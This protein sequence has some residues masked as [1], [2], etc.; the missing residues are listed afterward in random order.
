MATSKSPFSPHGASRAGDE[1]Q[2]LWGIEIL[3]DWLEHP[4]R[5][6]WVRFEYSEAGALDDVVAK[7]SSGGLICRQMKHTVDPS[8]EEYAGS[9]DWLCKQPA[10]TQG[11]RPSMLQHW[12]AALDR[13]LDEGPIEEA[14]LYTNRK[15]EP[16]LKAALVGRR[17]DLDRLADAAVRQAIED[18]L[19]GPERA[20]AF[21]DRFNFNLDLPGYEAFEEILKTRFK[22]SLGGDERGWAGLRD[23]ARTWA[24]RRDRASDQGRISLDDIRR[25]ALWHDPRA[26]SQEFAVPAD[27]ALPDPAMWDAL[28][29]EL[30]TPGSGTIVLAAGPGFGK[31]TFLSHLAARL[32]AQGVPVIR[33]HYYMAARERAE[34]RFRHTV[35]L[36]SLMAQMLSQHADLLG[37]Y[38]TRNP[39]VDDF[40]HWLA[41]AGVAADARGTSLTVVIDGLDHVWRQQG[42]VS[43]LAHLFNR[44]LPPPDGV[45]VVIGTQPL[46]DVHLPPRLLDH[47]PRDT[48]RTLPPL[49]EPAVR[50][51]LNGNRHRL[52]GIPP[53]PAGDHWLAEAATAFH[54][55][56][57]GHPLH[58]RYSMEA[59]IAHDLP[60][61]SADIISL[62][63]CPAGDI[64][65]YYDALCRGL[66]ETARRQLHLFAV[67]GFPWPQ[68]AL[69]QVLDPAR[70]HRAATRAALRSIRHLFQDTEQGLVPF[71]ASLLDHLKRSRNYADDREELLERVAAWLE[72]P[73][74]EPWRWAY[75][76][77]ILAERGDTAALIAGPT[78]A[79]LADAVARRRPARHVDRILTQ[80]GRCALKAGDL[81]RVVEIQVL[82]GYAVSAR[83]LHLHDL[84]PLT[85]CALC[86]TRRG[87][88]IKEMRADRLERPTL[89]VAALAE[90]TITE[91]DGQ[92]LARLG[93]TTIVDRLNSL[94][95]HPHSSL[96][97]GQRIMRALPCLLGLRM[98]TPTDLEIAGIGELAESGHPGLLVFLAARSKLGWWSD[99]PDLLARLTDEADRYEMAIG[100]LRQAT[101]AGIDWVRWSD[102]ACW[103]DG[104]LARAIDLA[105]GQ[106]SAQSLSPLTPWPAP[107]GDRFAYR[108]NGRRR[109]VLDL[110]RV[111]FACLI[112]AWGGGAAPVPTAWGGQARTAM[113]I[114]AE[115][116][117]RQLATGGTLDL[118]D[119]V[120]TLQR[121]ERDPKEGITD[122]RQREWDVRRASAEILLDLV[123]VRR[124]A[125]GI[126]Q[127]TAAEVDRMEAATGMLQSVRDALLDSRLAWLAPDALERFITHERNRLANVVE[128]LYQ[129]YED[130]ARCAWL[131][132]L[133]RPDHPDLERLTTLAARCALGYGHRK[134]LLLSE[135]MGAIEALVATQPAAVRRWIKRLVPFIDAVS[136]FTDGKENA[137]HKVGV[138]EVLLTLAPGVVPAY[139]RH[140]A[141]HDRHRADQVTALYIAGVDPET[142]EA[143]ALIAQA[144]GEATWKALHPD[145]D[146]SVG[147]D[148]P[149]HTEDRLR[150]LRPAEAPPQ[151][152]TF[153]P[154]RFVAF[155]SAVN[156]LPWNDDEDLFLAWYRHWRRQDRPAALSALATVSDQEFYPSRLHAT[157]LEAFHDVR[158]TAGARAAFPWL[159]RAHRAAMGWTFYWHREEMARAVWAEL[160]RHYPADWHT[161]IQATLA[162]DERA[163]AMP[164]MFGPARLVRFLVDMNQEAL[165]AAVVDRLVGTLLHRTA[166]LPLPRPLWA[167]D[168]DG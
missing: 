1:Y 167:E 147:R 121:G 48:W 140:L 69:L 104:P 106:Q 81:A 84:S 11:P 14:G 100:A 151:V 56:S 83:D 46:D 90:A 51:I 31:S 157:L 101:P 76:W 92:T 130:Y 64:T 162:D 77:L 105:R 10:G 115:A 123:G 36:E 132:S 30:R 40:G 139:I 7:L 95:G 4:D 150:R 159:V 97:D 126:P 153:P 117:G 39:V 82:A 45:R 131:V 94:S 60:A 72:G 88:L 44:L 163:G 128:A 73:A 13:V 129:R 85:A 28:I 32:G 96:D 2:D 143:W 136:D 59:L 62:A 142:P 27:Y 164:I 80:A 99:G 108:P 91:A 135:T 25:V 166:D 65:H 145:T 12:A 6:D 165:A 57:G 112:Q 79:W 41:T 152:E 155:Q 146:A 37:Y 58:L 144:G 18:Q 89:E 23:A 26:L 35:V 19:Q 119:I 8:K 15:P 158:P 127:I 17:I 55:L 75:R 54:Q 33:H 125:G 124:L 120:A 78:E 52:R 50:S 43:E 24:I 168:L 133:H 113:A 138:G 47:A 110:H 3:L 74:P 137:Y 116:V 63:P 66:D 67:A 68:E 42:V 29:Q 134:D 49:S 154:D 102:R 103:R 86:T 148:A 111:F 9:W 98:E 114:A 122:A 20:R 38:A 109:I 141:R 61:F 22:Q 21:F 16:E 149:S 118:V 5:Y 160:K 93:L 161:F 34:D 70:M 107:V 53:A 156:A 71:H 87:D